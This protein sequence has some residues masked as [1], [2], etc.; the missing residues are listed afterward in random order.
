[1]RTVAILPVKSFSRAKS[2]LGQA[3]PDRPALAAAMVADVLDALF[4]APSLDGV[5][6]VTA[7]PVASRVA[8]EMGAEVVHDP[9]ET[10]QSDAVLRGVDATD[11][12]RVLLVPGDC[13]AL[14]PAEVEALLAHA[15]PVVIVPD[16]HGTGTNALLLSPPRVMTPA[17]GEGSFERHSRLAREAGIDPEVAPVRTL[18]LDVDTPD[19][20]DALR[21]ALSSFAGGAVRTRALLDE[22]L[23]A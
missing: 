10:G 11:A 3:F 16:R 12:E 18:G 23:A 17:F 6:V 14:D 22:A 8:A 7:E 4:A 2:R 13:P 1:M 5:V 15:A 9:A 21:R 19:D 20:L